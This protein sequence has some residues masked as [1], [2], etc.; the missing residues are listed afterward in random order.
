MKMNACSH[1]LAH[2]AT[3]NPGDADQ[4]SLWNR[5]EEVLL[6]MMTLLC[7]TEVWSAVASDTVYPT[8]HQK[9]GHLQSLYGMVGSMA[10]F[11]LWVGLVNTKLQEN[12]D[13]LPQL[14]KM[15]D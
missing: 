12:L 3:A 10:T 2:D 9:Y 7:T 5:Q 4:V 8:V 15:L 1:H 11:N 14:Q 13:F 6:G